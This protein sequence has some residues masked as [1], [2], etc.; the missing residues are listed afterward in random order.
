[1]DS[2][3]QAGLSDHRLQRARRNDVIYVMKRDVDEANN[4]VDR[5]AVATMARRAVPVKHEPALLDDRDELAERAL[6]LWQVIGSQTTAFPPGMLPRSAVLK[7]RQAHRS[8]TWRGTRRARSRE[9]AGS[10]SAPASSM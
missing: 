1:R 2:V 9:R 4:P 7:K 6:Q 8:R 3:P 5:T 10:A